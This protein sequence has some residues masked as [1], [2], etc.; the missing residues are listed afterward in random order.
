MTMR[1]RRIA[2]TIFISAIFVLLFVAAGFL[3]GIEHVAKEST[4]FVFENIITF[5]YGL[6]GAGIIVALIKYFDPVSIGLIIAHFIISIG[7]LYFLDFKASHRLAL[8]LF[9]VCLI[10][11]VYYW[12]RFVVAR[13]DGVRGENLKHINGIIPIVYIGFAMLLRVFKL[14]NFIETDIDIPLISVIIPLVISVVAVILGVVLI[15]DRSDRK[16]YAGKLCV[17]FFVPF[18]ITFAMPLIFTEYTNYAFDTSVGERVDFIV[19]D[20]YTKHHSKGGRSHHIVVYADGEKVEFSTDRIVYDN[21]ELGAALPLYEH[22]G[23]YDMPYYEYR[24]DFVYKYI[25]D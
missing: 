13:N 17:L 18:L 9:V 4:Y 25:N 1:N 24:L 19:V 10:Y 7:R 11:T 21:Y 12:V 20:K 15:K 6:A 23:A 16:E 2:V 8:A 22:D 14:L 5:S 3:I